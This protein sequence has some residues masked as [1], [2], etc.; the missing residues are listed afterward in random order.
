MSSNTFEV[1]VGQS[2]PPFER[3]TGF[4]NWN[5]FA[6][7]NHEFVDIHMDDEA[8]RAAGYDSAFGMGN[9]L[10]SYLHCMLRDWIGDA[11][12]IREVRCQFRSPNT[13][14][15]KLTAGGT[16]TAVRDDAGRRLVDL[17]IWISDS[18]GTVLTPGSATVELVD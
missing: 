8:G 4:A 3:T 17:D 14:G 7:V 12:R 5:R 13:K 15:M 9:L 2:V 1:A 10:W 11:G 6:A 18:N 16:V